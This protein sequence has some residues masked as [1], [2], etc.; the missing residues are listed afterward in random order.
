M[1]YR[2]QV[3]VSGV[4][5]EGVEGGTRHV[6]RGGCRGSCESALRIRNRS[7]EAWPATRADK[8]RKEDGNK[9]RR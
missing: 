7:M 8:R 1:R 4:V 2:D 3:G 5:G 9:A 6:S